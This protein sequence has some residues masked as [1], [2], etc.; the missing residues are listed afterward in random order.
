VLKYEKNYESLLTLLEGDEEPKSQLA[1][2]HIHT[3]LKAKS[4]KLA[5]KLEKLKENSKKKLPTAA[6]NGS[7]SIFS[8]ASRRDCRVTLGLSSDVGSL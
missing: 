3:I 1:L 6:A 5:P 7:F 2:A 8:I 4:W